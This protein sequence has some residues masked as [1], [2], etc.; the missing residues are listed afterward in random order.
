MAFS[1]TNISMLVPLYWAKHLDTLCPFMESEFRAVVK[2]SQYWCYY[3][4]MKVEGVSALIHQSELSWDATLNPASY[5]QIG[6]VFSFLT[7]WQINKVENSFQPLK[8]IMMWATTNLFT[9]FF[10]CLFFFHVCD[11]AV[12][13]PC[14]QYRWCH[15]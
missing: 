2:N 8:L 7:M 6:Q 1:F 9:F 13:F 5:F 3:L 4:L 11:F 10:Y 15:K 14:F 12:Y